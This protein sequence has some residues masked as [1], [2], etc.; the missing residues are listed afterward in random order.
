MTREKDNL[1][2]GDDGRTIANMNIEGMPWYA[3][4]KEDS[5]QENPAGTNPYDLA[6]RRRSPDCH[7]GCPESRPPCGRRHLLRNCSVHPVLHDDLVPLKS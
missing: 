6:H 3:P 4:E 1:P 2:E 5:P 7:L